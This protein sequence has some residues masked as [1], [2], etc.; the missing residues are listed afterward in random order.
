MS[1][2]EDRLVSPTLGIC[3]TTPDSAHHVVGLARAAAKAGVSTDV[4][5]T[6]EGV[7]VITHHRFPELLAA[8]RVGVCEVS[9]RA[10]GYRGEDVP[11]LGEKDFVTQWRNAEMVQR[12]DRYLVL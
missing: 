6:G 3:V 9:Y 5:L 7:H 8:A 1:V 4:F 2:P 10:A 12:C 11:G